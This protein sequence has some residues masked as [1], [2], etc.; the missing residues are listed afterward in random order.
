MLPARC[1]QLRASSPRSPERKQKK[2]AMRRHH[3]QYARSEPDW[4]YVR[5]PEYCGDTI[6]SQTHHHN[7]A[8][9]S[10]FARCAIK[11][12]STLER[13]TAKIAEPD[14]DISAAPTSG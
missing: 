14:P 6:V 5:Y 10:D 2:S 8:S 9:S 7:S 12:P 13:K 3:R 1:Q 11:S 4:R